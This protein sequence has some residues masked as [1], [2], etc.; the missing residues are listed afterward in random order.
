MQAQPVILFKSKSRQLTA[1]QM[2]VKMEDRLPTMDSSVDQHPVTAFRNPFLTS[3][4]FRQHDDVPDQRLILRQ[5]FVNRV[6]MAVG[7]DEDVRGGDGVNI[8]ESGDQVIVIEDLGWRF[9]GDDLTEDAGHG[10]LG[11]GERVPSVSFGEDVKR[12][13]EGRGYGIDPYWD[14]QT[15]S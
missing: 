3:E 6:D 13:E 12:D 9:S 10:C 15:I 11:S 14:A 1:D 7:Y 8:S 5:Q 2:Q 4:L